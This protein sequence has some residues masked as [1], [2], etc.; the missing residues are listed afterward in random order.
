MDERKDIFISPKM[1][2]FSLVQIIDREVI[3][4]METGITHTMLTMICG[5]NL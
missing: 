3:I 5:K 1:V 2:L 4:K